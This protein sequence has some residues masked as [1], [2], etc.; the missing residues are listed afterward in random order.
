[1]TDI[2]LQVRGGEVVG[3]AGVSG[4]GQKELLYALSGEDVRAAP[5]SIT[6]A[7]TAAG[8]LSPRQ[9]RALGLQVVRQAH[10]GDGT[11]S[12]ALLGHKM[13]S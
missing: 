4:N 8:R 9:R 12:E 3:I 5:A 10:A 1:M 2:D 13:Q 7:G 11:T 6:V